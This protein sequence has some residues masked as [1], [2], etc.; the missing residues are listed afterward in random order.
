[1]ERILGIDP[2]PSGAAL[3]FWDGIEAYFIGQNIQVADACWWVEKR[4]SQVA[5]EDFVIY[6]PLDHHGRE[7]IKQ[8]GML[9]WICKDLGVPCTE[10][11]RADVLRHLVGATIGGDVALRAAVY[12]RFGGSRQAAIGTKKA[13]GPLYGMKGSHLL[14]AFAVALTAWDKRKRIPI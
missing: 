1:M 11:P 9:R 10:I 6:R 2:G 12:D 13:P 4:A 8:I 3:V 5:V 7:T 14:A